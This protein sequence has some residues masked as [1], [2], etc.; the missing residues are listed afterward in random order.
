MTRTSNT[1]L[2][3][4]NIAKL[5]PGDYI[6]AKHGAVIRHRG[7]V[8]SVVP[9]LGLAWITEAIPGNRRIIDTQEFT[10]WLIQ[11]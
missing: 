1:G 6:E 4:T 10:V 11:T 9:D 7:R 2:Q 8:D 5:K 3:I